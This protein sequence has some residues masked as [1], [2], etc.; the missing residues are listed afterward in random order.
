MRIKK[1]KKGFTLIELLVT[2]A[3][4]AILAAML[5][6]ALRNSKKKA[7]Q[8][9][10][11][12]NL[13]QWSVAGQAYLGDYNDYFPPSGYTATSPRTTWVDILSEE[14]G[15][16]TY[17]VGSGLYFSDRANLKGIHRCPSETQIDT[18]STATYP[19]YLYNQCLGTFKSTK[20]TKPASTLYLIDGDRSYAGVISY[21]KRTEYGWEYCSVSYMR[22]PGGQVNVLFADGHCES[23]KRPSIGQTLDIQN[24]GTNI[25]TD[26][27]LW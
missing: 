4:I 1:M 9:K 24:H 15:K 14:L 26:N 5:L 16:R 25:W 3:I 10:C 12:S 22:H 2:I 17:A 21:L 8:I 20:I 7:E 19:D 6:P 23:R 27:Y 11:S 18:L 13:K